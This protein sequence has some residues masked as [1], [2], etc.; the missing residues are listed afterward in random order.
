[1]NQKTVSTNSSGKPK[2]VVKVLDT[3]KAHL[4]DGLVHY[5][6]ISATFSDVVDKRMKNNCFQNY[7]IRFVDVEK[8][9][10]IPAVHL[11]PHTLPN[12]KKILPKGFKYASTNS[13]IHTHETPE[14]HVEINFRN[15]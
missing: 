2:H 13:W 12:L 10:N 8:D 7:T 4:K 6:S 1:M 11:Y 14:I 5:E 3:L 15:I 9:G